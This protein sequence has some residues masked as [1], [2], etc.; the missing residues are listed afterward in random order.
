MHAAS[1]TNLLPSSS[2]EASGIVA[3][4]VNLL[5]SRFDMMKQSLWDED[6]STCFYSETLLQVPKKM[7]FIP[8]AD[9]Q[10]HSQ[11]SDGLDQID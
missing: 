11:L 9:P 3:E 5:L 1:S 6:S 4:T 10:V 7:K 8:V 2:K